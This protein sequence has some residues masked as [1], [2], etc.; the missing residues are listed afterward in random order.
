M[1]SGGRSP[2]ALAVLQPQQLAEEL[3]RRWI[4]YMRDRRRAAAPVA[5]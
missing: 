2:V 5:G 1:L 3:R 4:S